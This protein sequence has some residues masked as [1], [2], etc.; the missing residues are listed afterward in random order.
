MLFTNFNNLSKL[1]LISWNDI[2]ALW[3]IHSHQ[4]WARQVG[5]VSHCC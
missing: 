2:S 1:L 3:Q 4:K 5:F